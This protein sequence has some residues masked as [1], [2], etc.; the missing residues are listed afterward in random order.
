M[1]KLVAALFTVAALTGC[2]AQQLQTVETDIGLAV[3]DA[4]AAL[5]DLKAHP[6]LVDQAE[7]AVQI[8][9][10]STG[11]LQKAAINLIKVF[12]LYKKNQ[13]TIDQVQSALDQFNTILTSTKQVQARKKKG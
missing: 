1:K 3:S 12:E 5:T 6:E 9:A 10:N 4:S 8:V 13:A 11:P 2:T 7:T